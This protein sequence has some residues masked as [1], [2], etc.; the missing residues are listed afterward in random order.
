MRIFGLIAIWCKSD[1]EV[2][3]IEWR[4]VKKEMI[5]G[6][7]AFPLTFESNEV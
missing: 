5:D 6:V 1:R 2:G 7:V 4:C 3:R